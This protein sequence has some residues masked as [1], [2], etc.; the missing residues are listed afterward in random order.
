MKRN[1][2]AMASSSRLHQVIAI[3]RVACIVVAL[4]IVFFILYPA[5]RIALWCGLDIA[6]HLPVWFHR[7]AL[8]LLGVKITILGTPLKDRPLL[9]ASNHVSWL[10]ISLLGSLFPLSFIAKSEVNAWPVIGVFARLQRTIYIERQRRHATGKTTHEIGERLSAGDCLVLFAEGTSSD[11]ARVLPF[12]SSLLGGVRAA[13]LT[14]TSRQSIAVQ[15]MA[16]AY[17]G[18]RGMP[19][20]RCKRPTYAWYGDMELASHLFGVL[21]DGAID[22]AISFGEPMA[23]GLRD[24]RKRAA[25]DLELAAR[26][27]LHQ[28]LTGRAVYKPPANHILNATESR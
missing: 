17:R 14:E 2:S 26:A 21:A 1:L 16:I 27:L 15:P 22:V 13:L 28:A 24:D 6:R 20:D 9:L 7:A 3:A 12:K 4:T 18:Y 10:D 8:A 23:L 11:G 25:Q 19:I 5:Q